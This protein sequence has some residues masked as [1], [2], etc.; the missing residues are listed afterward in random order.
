MSPYFS[1]KYSAS[2]VFKKM[3]P[4]VPSVTAWKNSTA[5]RFLYT[6]TRNA[7]FLTLS[8]GTCCSGQLFSS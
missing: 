8:N 6:S 2:N 1:L 5:I 4:P 3:R 7:H